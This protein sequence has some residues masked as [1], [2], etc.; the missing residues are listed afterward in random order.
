MR[1]FSSFLVGEVREEQGWKNQVIT[2]E[3]WKM[4]GKRLSG[5]E[6]CTSEIKWKHACQTSLALMRH[7]FQG[8]NWRVSWWELP[9]FQATPNLVSSLISLGYKNLS[10][11]LLE[12][13]MN[14]KCRAEY[15]RWVVFT[16]EY[17]PS[18]IR[19]HWLLKKVKMG[20]LA[21]QKSS[22]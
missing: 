12:F 15:R 9:W 21:L 20:V 17:L 14:G 18:D 10:K 2:D 6:G 11:S 16:H 8:V 13:R 1:W 3:A 19:L 5:W 22:C 4:W 7:N